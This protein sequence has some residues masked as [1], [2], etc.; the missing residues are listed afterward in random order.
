L[1][2]IS[3][4]G[5][6]LLWFTPGLTQNPISH[7]FPIHVNASSGGIQTSGFNIPEGRITNYT[8]LTVSISINGLNNTYTE[9]AD[10]AVSVVIGTDPFSIMPRSL[11]DLIPP[12][13]PG[14]KSS[15]DRLDP[16][17]KSILTDPSGSFVPVAVTVSSNV[18]F[19]MGTVS[20]GIVFTPTMNIIPGK[21]VVTTGDANN[22]FFTAVL[23][24]PEN[25]SVIEIILTSQNN[26]GDIFP[27]II[28]ASGDYCPASGPI[29]TPN[30]VVTDIPK[31]NYTSFEII[32]QKVWYLEFV[33]T[34]EALGIVDVEIRT[35]LFP[36]AQPPGSDSTGI[37]VGVTITIVIVI[38]GVAIVVYKR[39]GA[40]QNIS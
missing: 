14:D 34:T 10:I 38:A 20:V 36:P 9:T 7:T 18:T 4:F 23:P 40:Y 5:L 17:G 32:S 24:N 30:R 8:L 19:V 11:I 25:A 21:F 31:Q 22:Q 6:L 39:K 3:I 12:L 16:C 1:S 26:I 35:K 15:T 33:K 37:I 29:D 28:A 27:Q 13:A 2:F